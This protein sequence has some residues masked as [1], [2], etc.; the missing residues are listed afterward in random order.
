MLRGEEC[1]GERFFALRVMVITELHDRGV[2]VGV[3]GRRR[4]RSLE[5]EQCL[6]LLQDINAAVSLMFECC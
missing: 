6:S 3:G 1:R 2:G 4:G 5:E